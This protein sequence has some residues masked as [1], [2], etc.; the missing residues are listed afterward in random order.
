MNNTHTKTNK[1]ADKTTRHDTPPRPP[2]STDQDEAFF[3][4][5]T[6][7]VH[8]AVRTFILF[9]AFDLIS[10]GE[11]KK[12]V[13]R[14]KDNGDVWAEDVYSQVHLASNLV[15]K[16]VNE[17]QTLDDFGKSRL[18]RVCTEVMAAVTPPAR[19]RPG[20]SLCS[21]TGLRSDEC[22]DLTRVGKSMSIVTVH[23]RFSHFV[24]ML[25]Y[26][27]KFEHV[28]KVMA[29]HWIAH[30]HA[31]LT[32]PSS[33]D[34]HNPQSADH[35]S[36]DADN[37]GDAQNIPLDDQKQS[38]FVSALCND[39]Q[40]E[41][42]PIISAMA[43]GFRH[44]FLHTMRSIRTH[45]ETPDAEV[46]AMQEPN[47]TDDADAEQQPPAAAA[48]SSF[49][50]SGSTRPHKRARNAASVGVHRRTQPDT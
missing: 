5:S 50:C 35:N 34:A 27:V 11:Y 7:T 33:A 43:R 15:R 29:R 14:S 47:K 25:W 16:L 8:N 42:E 26:V 9:K 41:Q 30:H 48:A 46:V 6:D 49:S 32:S 10:D 39:F 31:A 2:S 28:C 1:R 18:R 3:G 24:V 13:V 45:K 19:R 21:I 22:I 20:W 12:L 23:R 38:Q 17:I 4:A 37:Q 44:A 36:S 40:R